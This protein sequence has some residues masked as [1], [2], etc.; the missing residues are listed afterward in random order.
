MDL[1]LQGYDEA[2]GREFQRRLI[3]KVRALPGIE[4]AGLV[5]ALPLSLNINNNGIFIE[6]RPVPKA[7]EVPM[8]AMYQAGPGYFRTARTK[9]IAGR[10]FDERDQPGSKHV[11]V[12]NQ[13]F[14]RQLLL[15]ENPL[16]KR[17]RYSASQGD[18]NEIVGIVEDGKYRSLGETPMAA[19]FGSFQDWRSTTTVVARSSMPE[20]SV[21]GL[22]RRAVM[23]LD[24]TISIFSAGSLTEQLGLVLFP[25][26]IAA[27]VL[28]AFGVLALILASTGIYAIMAYAVSR[29]T[30]EIGIRMALGASAPQVVRVVLGRGALLLSIGAAIGIASA[31]AASRLF[32]PILYGVSSTDPATY[33]LALALMTLVAFA[34]CWFPAR[35]AIKVDPVRSLRTE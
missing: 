12:V 25:A 7:A 29:R 9:L 8:A 14:V 33:S 22:L 32:S 6:G 10:D 27:T 35:R 26:R 34:A 24:P 30:R 15:N 1:G 16:G 21:V 4:S 31:L 13:A 17:F 23:E 18:W 11:V 5:N 3:E 19:V 2:R 20:Q 28:S